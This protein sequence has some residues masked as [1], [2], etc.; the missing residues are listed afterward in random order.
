MDLLRA[1]EHLSQLLG[2][3]RPAGSEAPRETVLPKNCGHDGTRGASGFLTSC[4][5]PC[6]CTQAVPLARDPL[7][8][9]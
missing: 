9:P 4:R 2:L 8:S 7:R 6:L 1:R 3:Q 5:P